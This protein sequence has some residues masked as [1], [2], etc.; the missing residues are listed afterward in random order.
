[1]IIWRSQ[2]QNVVAL[3]SCEAEYITTTI[4]ACQDVCLGRLLTELKGEEEAK[5]FT[6]KKIDN[7]S[8]I[9]LSRNPVFHDCSKHIDT[10]YHFIRQCVE[11]DMVRMEQVDTNNQLANILMKSLGRDHFIELDASR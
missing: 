9:Q 8:A 11:E 5:M 6:L 4:A 3:S 10:K 1:L 2:K 7:L